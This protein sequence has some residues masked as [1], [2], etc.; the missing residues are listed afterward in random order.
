MSNRIFST[1]DFY[2]AKEIPID[3]QAN[4]E[5]ILSA[6]KPPKLLTSM[7]EAVMLS[8]IQTLDNVANPSELALIQACQMEGSGTWLK[9]IPYRSLNL[10][11]APA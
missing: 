2:R 4:L 3:A 7:V 10:C 6:A 11:M 8:E 5:A 1:E 9:C